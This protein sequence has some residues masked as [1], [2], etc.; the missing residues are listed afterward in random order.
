MT[1]QT[2]GT[3]RDVWEANQRRLERKRLREREY[4]K[5]NREKM[6]AYRRARKARNM[7][8]IKP[9]PEGP[10]VKSAYHADWHGSVYTCPELTYRG[11]A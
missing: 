5:A 6:N 9:E 11:L 2:K 1:K 8:A 4:A 3:I 7:P 10:K